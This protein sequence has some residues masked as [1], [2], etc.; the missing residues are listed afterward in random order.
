MADK[1]RYPLGN[2]R[3]LA[4][5]DEMDDF[6]LSKHALKEMEDHAKKENLLDE[7]REV[8]KKLKSLKIFKNKY[9]IFK[10]SK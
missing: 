4:I 6:K 5:G 8:V 9:L 1:P 10:K 7:V 3:D 2:C